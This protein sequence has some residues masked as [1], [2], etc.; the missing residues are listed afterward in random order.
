MKNA[1]EK[2]VKEYKPR[3]MNKRNVPVEPFDKDALL[4]TGNL[5]VREVF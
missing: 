1:G 3:Y 2:R 4:E 5:C